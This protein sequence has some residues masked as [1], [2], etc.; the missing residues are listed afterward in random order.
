MENAT[1]L[2]VIDPDTTDSAITD[3]AD[4]ALANQNHLH[5]LLLEAAPP[6]PIYA[7]ST[8]PYGSMNIPDDWG[9]TL[10]ET[11]KFLNKRETE[12][13]ALLAR[14][15]VSADIQSQLCV[16]Q[17]IKNIVSSHARVCDIGHIASNRQDINREAANGILLHSP[18]ALMRNASPSIPVDHVFVAWNPSQAAAASVHA[19]LPYLRAAKQ[20]TIACFDPTSSAHTAGEDPGTDVAAWLAHHGC[21]VTVA[22]FPTGGREV[23][24]CIQD[25]AQELGT[26]LIVMGAYGHS[27]M[28]EA[29][30]GGTTRSM[31]RQT[32]M[33]VLFAH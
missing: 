12:I 9:E 16:P 6:L 22:Q 29:V 4:A 26:D 3:L 27:R 1:T 28:I 31:M 32:D 33:P 10:R 21:H 15:G 5:C 13:E 18:I 25:R 17:E 19:A 7:Y 2:L 23:A 20:V 8:P 11:R 24:D 14:T 30:F